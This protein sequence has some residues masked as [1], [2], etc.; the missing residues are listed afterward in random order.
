LVLQGSELTGDPVCFNTNR[1][2]L[3]K[4]LALGFEEIFVFERD[5]PVL[6]QDEHRRFVWALLEPSGVIRPGKD[7]IRIESPGKDAVVTQSIHRK[8]RRTMAKTPSKDKRTA[9]NGRP[10]SGKATAVEQAEP[11][12]SLDQAIELRNTLRD[13]ASKTAELIRTLKREKKQ[14]KLVK[15]ALASLREL[16]TSLPAGTSADR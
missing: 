2:L 13:A 16:Q 15:S 9:G 4:A 10:P 6:C 12:T 3:A 7:P 11:T 14:A 8:K 5:K 1:Q